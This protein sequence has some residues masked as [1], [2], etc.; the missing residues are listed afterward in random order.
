MRLKWYVFMQLQLKKRYEVGV[1]CRGEGG[2][3][4]PFPLATEVVWRVAKRRERNE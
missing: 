4:R 1:G 2:F 3:F